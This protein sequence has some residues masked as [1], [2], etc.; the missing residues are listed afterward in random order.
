MELAG[1]WS[2]EATSLTADNVEKAA[3]YLLAPYNVN[4]EWFD[5]SDESLVDRDCRE[6]C[7]GN[8]RDMSGN[9]KE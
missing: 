9:C 5:D 8:Y 2:F 6:E 3:H 4:G 1:A 7:H